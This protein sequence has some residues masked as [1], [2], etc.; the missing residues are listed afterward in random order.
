MKYKK[1][2]I[3][4]VIC[5]AVLATLSSLVGVFSNEGV[6]P[7]EFESVYGKTVEIFGSG[8]YKRDS[9]TYVIQGRAQDAIIAAIGVPILLI[10]LYFA[11]KNLLKGKLLLTG[12]LTFFLYTYM[13]YTFLWIYNY[14]FLV[15]IALMSSSFFALALSI[16]SIDLDELK[17][18]FNEK[19]PIKLLAGFQIVLGIFIGMLWLGR[20]L[21]A[22]INNTVPVDLD[23]YSSLVIQG[24]DLGFIV[25]L[26]F[27][28]AILLLRRNVFGY[29]LSSIV[30]TKGVV[31]GVSVT[32]VITSLIYSGK[33]PSIVELVMFPSITL[34]STYLMFIFLKNVKE[35]LNNKVK[36]S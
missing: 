24:L 20:I 25:P 29:L 35:P 28:S 19:L 6:E 33:D 1:A 13:G 7:Y 34:I 15:Y 16:M 3:T 17:V 36:H 27:L 9:L 5:V 8:V 21:P 32:A 31:L 4:L 26:A 12:M 2:I 14:L 11:Q 22:V 18:A 30:I 10:S 23:H